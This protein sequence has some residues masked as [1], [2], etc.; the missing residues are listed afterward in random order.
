MLISLPDELLQALLVKLDASAACRLSQI[1]KAMQHWIFRHARER[2]YAWR[3]ARA[4]LMLCERAKVRV[5]RLQRLQRRARARNP[6]VWNHFT[7]VGAAVNCMR[8]CCTNEND[9][10]TA[11][12]EQVRM[13]TT[14]MEWKIGFCTAPLWKHLLEAHPT[15]YTELRERTP[16]V[17]G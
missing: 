13:Y 5:Q 6:G 1:D 7:S 3:Q 2:A 17:L 10:G 9:N 15:L 11:C 14:P 8:C 16:S 12:G 4:W